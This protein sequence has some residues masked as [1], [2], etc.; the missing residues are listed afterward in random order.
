MQQRILGASL[1]TAVVFA[2]ACTGTASAGLIKALRL[3]VG[4]TALAVG[5][6]IVASSTNTT[7]SN[8]FWSLACS[9]SALTGTIGQNNK[10]KDDFMPI[11]EGRFPAAETKGCARQ[12][13]IRHRVVAGI[14]R[15]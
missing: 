14:P 6:P 4:G 15:N 3:Q 8:A 11:T 12:L 2:L 13:R 1:A 9:E 7:I 10:A 5:A